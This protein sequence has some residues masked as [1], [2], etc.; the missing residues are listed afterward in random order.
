[1]SGALVIPFPAHHARA[2]RVESPDA[3]DFWFFLL[4][5]MSPKRRD[6]VIAEAER[7]GVIGA[8]E[9]E[10]LRTSWSDQRELRR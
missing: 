10:I 2:A 6:T 3:F 7:R 9:A 4:E 5:P 1:M 8:R